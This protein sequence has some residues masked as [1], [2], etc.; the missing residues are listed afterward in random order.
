MEICP[1]GAELLHEG[2]RTDRHKESN[3]RFSQ[4]CEGARK[5]NFCPGLAMQ[6]YRAVEVQL[7]PFLILVVEGGTQLT[8]GPGRFTPR[9]EPRYRLNTRLG[10]PH[11]RSGHFGKKKHL[12]PLPGI[13]PAS[14]KSSHVTIPT[15]VPLAT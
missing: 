9:K 2:G 15:A 5:G 13:K 11:S 6:A 10:G 14:S 12:F 3:S 8:S 7:R 4:F 1:V